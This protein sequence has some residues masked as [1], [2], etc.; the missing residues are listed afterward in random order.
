MKNI[1]WIP[2]AAIVGLVVGS[3]GPREDIKTLQQKM[4]EERTSKK[5]SGTTGFDAFAKLAN[6]PDVAKKSVKKVEKRGG[7]K[8]GPTEARRRGD[9]GGVGSAADHQAPQPLGQR[10]SS[11]VDDNTP[12]PSQPLSRQDLRMRIDEAAEL[13]RT[14]VALATTQ[15]KEKLGIGAG[16]PADGSFDDAVSEMNDNLREVMQALA[17][18]IESAGK[19]TPELSL[20][21]MGECS[22]VLAEG[23]DAL[24]AGVPPEK[25]A[26]VSEMPAWEFVDPSVAEPLISVQDKLQDSRIRFSPHGKRQ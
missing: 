13:W 22:R 21:M 3:W 12:S 23:Y 9:A 5:V 4:E 7:G 1:L 25:G 17:D 10:T 2:L 8:G 15:W 14:R 24:R 26:T 16:T 6:I 19:L 11:S 20:R 18:E